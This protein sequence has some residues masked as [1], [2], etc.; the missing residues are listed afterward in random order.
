MCTMYYNNELPY[1]IGPTDV[2]QTTILYVYK[3]STVHLYIHNTPY[4]TCNVN[5]TMIALKMVGIIVNESTD[6]YNTISFHWSSNCRI[7]S[8]KL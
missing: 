5:I 2:N 6:F 7:V 4:Q 3:N 1:R 8:G